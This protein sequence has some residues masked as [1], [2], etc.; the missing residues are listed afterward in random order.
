MHPEIDR[1]D[2][3]THA[4]FRDLLIG[5]VYGQD[6]QIGVEA[7]ETPTTKPRRREI[8]RRI[9]AATEELLVKDLYIYEG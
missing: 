7:I 5:R 6:G 3:V 8:D 9:L 2:S 1:L 4:R